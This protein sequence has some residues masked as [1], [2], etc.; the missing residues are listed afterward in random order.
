[1]SKKKDQTFFSHDWLSD[2]EFKTWLVEVSGDN[3]LTR[4]KYRKKSFNL[5]NM[6]HQALVSHGAGQK[7]QNIKSISVS[8]KKKT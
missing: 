6:G 1:M 5:S 8:T 7:H 4:C 2:P 3:K